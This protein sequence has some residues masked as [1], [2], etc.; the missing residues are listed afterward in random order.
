[1]K[2]AHFRFYGVLNDFLP[3]GKRQA[4]F[5]CPISGRQTV[6]H[7]IEA[8]G[9]PHVE[10]DLILVNGHAVDF[11]RVVADG[12]S[13]SV[14]PAF[15][16]IDIAALSCVRPP[17]LP[18]PV[19]V[20]DA[21]LGRL[22]AYLRML[23]FD[24]LYGADYGDGELSQIAAGGPR[25]LLTRDAGL[26]MRRAVTHGY[27]VR[28]TNPRRQLLE[29]MRRFDLVDHISPFERCLRCNGVLEPV[30]KE[31]VLASVPPRSREHYDEFRRCGGCRRVYW[32][33]SHYQR[34]QRLIEQLAA[35]LRPPGERGG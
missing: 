34:M 8:L 17:P 6:K 33:G 25:I 23:G 3:A 28:E 1:M 27:Y 31:T 16:A 35:A 7:L 26:L 9:V 30:P 22:A 2:S 21:H 5:A 15:E 20:L 13:V 32:N 12:D 10:V 19:F 18:A 24:A 4:R 14:Y 11:S 29:V